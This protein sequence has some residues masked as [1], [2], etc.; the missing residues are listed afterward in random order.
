MRICILAALVFVA[1]CA[2]E[3]WTVLDA[4]GPA[5]AGRP[6]VHERATLTEAEAA[7]E[8][9][10]ADGEPDVAGEIGTFSQ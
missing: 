3:N 5:G 6:V 8:A 7:S 4:P 1:A 9:S 2:E 10:E